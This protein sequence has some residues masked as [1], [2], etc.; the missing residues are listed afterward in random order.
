[1]MGVKLDT[2]DLADVTAA[3]RSL[4]PKV[5]RKLLIATG[6][7]AARVIRDQAR[8]LAPVSAKGAATGARSCS[9]ES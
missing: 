8:A 3:I 6:R 5:R 2:S 4:P 1:M 7:T 9:P